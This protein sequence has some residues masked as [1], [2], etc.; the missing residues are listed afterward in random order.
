MEQNH[1]TQPPV[2]EIDRVSKRFAKVLANHDVSITLNKGE[3]VALLGENG[4][5]KSTIMNILYG[6]YHMTSGEIRI[7]GVKKNIATPRDAMALGI[8]MIQQHFSLVGAHTVT[9]NIILGNVKGKIDY[10]AEEKKIQDLSDRYR[11][12]VSA[13]AK[14]GDLPVGMQ[15]KVEIMKAL[16]RDTRILI[17][18]EPTAVLMPQEI[19]TLMEFIRSFVAEGNSVFFITHKMR[20]V[21]Q[22]ADR[23]VIMRNGEV[24]GTVRKSEVQMSDLARLMIG[25]DLEV[26]TRSDTDGKKAAVRLKVDHVTVERR[27]ELPLL[28]DL[29]F[30]IHAGEILGV[31]GVSG[32]GQDSLCEL[33]YGALPPTSGRITLDGKDITNLNVAQHIALGIGYCASDRYRY[34]MVADMSLSENMMLKSSYLH[35]WDKGGWINWKNVDLYTQEKIGQYTIKAPDPTVTIGSLSGGNQQKAVV[36]RE[37][38]MGQNF[39]IFDQPTRGLDLGAINYVHKTIL[40][41]RDAGKSILLVSTELSE[42]FTLSDRIAVICEGKFMG[43]F[44]NGDLSTEQIGMLMAGVPIEDLPKEEKSAARTPEKEQPAKTGSQDTGGKEDRIDE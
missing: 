5:G 30:E 17:M 27:H 20:E 7:D 37:V 13:K 24:S 21:M 44:R 9:E 6:I 26:L 33:L 28:T 40:A 42:I 15:Q 32:N 25:H 31:A 43:I 34:G 39:V 41:Q 38:D 16:Y 36:A 11:F 22:V 4:A 3:V 10:E 14:V 2:V 23:I 8:S 18:D 19:D 29:D 35:R 12:G 1:N